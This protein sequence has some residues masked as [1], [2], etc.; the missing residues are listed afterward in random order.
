[1]NKNDNMVNNAEKAVKLLKVISN[2]TRLMTLCLLKNKEYSVSEL[3]EALGIAQSSL[4]QNLGVLR[5]YGCVKTRREAQT[6]YYSLES[7]EIKV[8][9]DTLYL[10]YCK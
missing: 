5:E 10:L 1:M 3:N 4:S 6:I 9:I 2:R 7:D 8:L